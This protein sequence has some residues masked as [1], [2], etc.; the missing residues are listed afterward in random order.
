MAKLSKTI[1]I[2]TGSASLPSEVLIMCQPA[3]GDEPETAGL[4]VRFDAAGDAVGRCD[5]RMV[6][7][8]AAEQK[9]NWDAL[10]AA[11]APF[12]NAAMADTGLTGSKS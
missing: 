6:G 1:E 11:L 5:P 12:I 4:R 8:T 9:K 10:Q 2:D 7:K 3:H